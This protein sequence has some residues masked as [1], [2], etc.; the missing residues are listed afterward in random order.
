MRIKTLEYY[1]E[2][3]LAREIEFLSLRERGIFSRDCRGT[4]SPANND[5]VLDQSHS[6]FDIGSMESRKRPRYIKSSR[7]ITKVLVKSRHQKY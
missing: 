5:D 1:L 3:S 7:T 4:E 6:I 2:R